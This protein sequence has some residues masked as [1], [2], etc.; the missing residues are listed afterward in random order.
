MHL[1]A[2][3]A[4]QNKLTRFSREHSMQLS[5]IVKV[6]GIAIKIIG[7]ES[8][9]EL[10]WFYEFSFSPNR[11]RARVNHKL[12][13]DDGY[14]LTSK[15]P[16]LCPSLLSFIHRCSSREMFRTQI[17]VFGLV[18]SSLRLFVEPRKHL[19]TAISTETVELYLPKSCANFLDL[20]IHSSTSEPLSS[21]HNPSRQTFNYQNES[22]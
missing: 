3:S 2:I 11:W 7:S 8:S 21:A 17:S 14:Y 10:G 19:M 18:R 1:P 6:Y 4:D 5:A 20:F 9:L 22:K 16:K 15:A 12:M 13:F